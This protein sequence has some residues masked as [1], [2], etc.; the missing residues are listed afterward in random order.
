MTSELVIDVAREPAL[1]VLHATTPV[2]R[3]TFGLDGDLNEATASALEAMVAW[4]ESSLACSRSDAL[5]LAS[6]SVDLSI[7]QVVNQVWGVHAL[8]AGSRLKEISSR[9]SLERR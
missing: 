3:V 5:M 4:M 2:G 6:V 7:T 9:Y 8:W 1:R